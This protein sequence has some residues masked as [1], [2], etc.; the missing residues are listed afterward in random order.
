MTK[1]LPKFPLK[2]VFHLIILEWPGVDPIITSWLVKS[3]K[4]IR[5]HPVSPGLGASVRNGKCHFLSDL[6]FDTCPPWRRWG[7]CCGGWARPRKPCHWHRHQPPDSHK[8]ARSSEM[9]LIRMLMMVMLLAPG[10]KW[11]ISSLPSSV[12]QFDPS[13][14]ELR[15]ID[16]SMGQLWSEQHVYCESVRLLERGFRKN[17]ITLTR[18]R[19]TVGWII[20]SVKAIHNSMVVDTTIL[21]CILQLKPD[22]GNSTLCFKFM[23]Y[24]LDTGRTQ[25]L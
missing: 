2:N 8:W 16:P 12:E 14:G 4:L 21:S 3:N 25:A 13:M 19:C 5:V 23:R 11:G 17:L 18:K 10:R 6:L 22:A 24:V 9:I 7:P 15:S 20:N 1:F